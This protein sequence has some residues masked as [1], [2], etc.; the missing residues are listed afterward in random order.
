MRFVHTDASTQSHLTGPQVSASCLAISGTDETHSNLNFICTGLDIVHPTFLPPFPRT[1]FTSQ[2]FRLC[3][4]YYEGSES[5]HSFTWGRRPPH[6]LRFT[7][8]S[9]RLQPR[10]VSTHRFSH[11]SSVSSEFQASPFSWRLANNIP[12]NRVR[13]PADRQFA[14]GCFP[15]RLTTTQ[16]PSATELWHTPTWTCTMLINRHHGRTTEPLR[17]RC[18]PTGLI[19]T[20]DH[21]YPPDSNHSGL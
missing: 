21:H 16:L 4:R 5:C 8:P 14:S 7:F 17:G 1:G 3:L 11:H 9:F 10:D 2:D 20:T 19:P 15:P 6:L 12:P 13:Y 18:L